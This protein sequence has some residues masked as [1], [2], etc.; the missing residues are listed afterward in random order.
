MEVFGSLP[1]DNL[2]LLLGAKYYTKYGEE[3]ATSVSRADERVTVR[4][5]RFFPNEDLQLLFNAADVGVFPFSDVLTSGS[6]ITA[7]SFAIPV[8][9]PATG[10]VPEAVLPDAGLVYDPVDAG[11][12]RRAMLE[13]QERDIPAWKR[14]ARA[15][16]HELDWAQIAERTRYVYEYPGRKRENA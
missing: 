1:G 6:V 16:A 13:A 4:S 3:V 2:R 15:R 10:C 5:S 11:G 14:A 9:V 7:L 8:I 12:L